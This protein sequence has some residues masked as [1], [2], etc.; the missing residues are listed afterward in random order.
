MPTQSKEIKDMYCDE[1]SFFKYVVPEIYRHVTLDFCDMQ[2]QSFIDF[3]KKWG[4]K[5]TSVFLHGTYGSGKTHFAFAMLREMF[6]SCPLK[7]WPRYFTSPELDKRLLK[8]LKSEEGDEYE[9]KN[10]SSQDILFI[11]DIGRETK[12][13]RLRN[14]Y[15]EI[16]NYRYSNKLPTILTSNFDLEDL[17][18]IIDGSISSRIQEWN[19]LKFKDRDLRIAQ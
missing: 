12:S 10:I 7:L 5:P 17:D 8:A 6:K 11:D 15:F 18:E 4:K 9:I 14:Q 3:A 13:E 19:I 2:P 1:R 16:L